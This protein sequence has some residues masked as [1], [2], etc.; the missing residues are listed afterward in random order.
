MGRLRV[1]DALIES[2]RKVNVAISGM[3]GR[4]G[5][6]GVSTMVEGG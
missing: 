3:D 4:A 5:R 6:F 1:A 2:D